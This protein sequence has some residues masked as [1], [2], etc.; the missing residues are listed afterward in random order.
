M[1]DLVLSV[2]QTE[3]YDPEQPGGCP[4]RW[5]FERVD[6]QA[7]P[8]SAS[9]EDGTAGHA[10]FATHLRGEA[11]PK[12]ARMLKAVRGALH[13]LPAPLPPQRLIESRFDGQPP[14][15]EKS[16]YSPVDIKR[17]L[18]LGG[19][20]WDGYVDLR[21]CN[22]DTVT[23]WD[24]KFS[25]DID[26]YAR[27]ADRLIRT[28]QMPVYALDS[29]RIW[30]DAQRFRLVHL[31]VSRRGVRSFVREQTVGRSEIATR[32]GEIAALVTRIQETARA[33]SQED[34]PAN[35]KACDI[36]GGC[37]HQS[38]CTAFRRKP[39]YDLS[40]EEKALFG[41]VSEVTGEKPQQSPEEL[42]QLAAEAPASANATGDGAAAAEAQDFNAAVVA[43]GDVSIPL[44]QAS[45]PTP[46]E[47]RDYAALAAE[48]AKPDTVGKL[49][50]V[51]TCKDCPH[52]AH[53]GTQ[54]TGKR[55]RGQCRCG[56]AGTAP[57]AA[58]EVQAALTRTAA[59]S[60]VQG[61]QP[62]KHLP[63]CVQNDAGKWLC[64]DGCMAGQTGGEGVSSAPL[65]ELGTSG[66]RTGGE[67]FPESLRLRGES[68]PIHDPEAWPENSPSG[69]P[70]LRLEVE[71]GPR[72]A[73]ILE[74]LAPALVELLKGR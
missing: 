27:P 67:P 56:A 6:G 7:R 51:A 28:I 29:L 38:I 26:A 72:A 66:G 46:Q 57:A 14:R 54:C 5:W 4:R 69:R 71:F 25:S 41:M 17:T 12:R 52:P 32:I 60:I 42:K 50:A 20:P 34:V 63:T 30:P 44:P 18:W 68:K 33:K 40:E 62:P 16:T 74:K 8:G 13:H 3:T 22:S 11:L 37:P 70:A 55:G 49:G 59:E 39:V 64:M 21:W 36:Y 10:L 23:V 58:G 2:S 53:P 19:V 47:Q 1:R 45:A 24:H 65:R 48:R 9:A 73:V 31:Y 35:R 43:L 61:D 15:L